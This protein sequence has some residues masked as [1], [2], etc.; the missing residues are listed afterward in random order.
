MLIT[1]TF[2][3]LQEVLYQAENDFAIKLNVT[4]MFNALAY[5]SSIMRF[6]NDIA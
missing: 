4:F 1:S 6:A 2:K 3:V 5:Y